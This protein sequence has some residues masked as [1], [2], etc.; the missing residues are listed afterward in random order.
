MKRIVPDG[1][2]P[3]VEKALRHVNSFYPEIT[4]VVYMACDTW[5]YLTDEG[6]GDA[7]L[8]CDRS[9][10]LDAYYSVESYPC[11]FAL[12]EDEE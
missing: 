1:Y 5:L 12:V 6:E 7:L 11:V 4:H 2:T 8:D 3:E 9:I 10:L